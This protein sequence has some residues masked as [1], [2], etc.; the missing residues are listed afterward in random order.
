MDLFGTAEHPLATTDQEH[1]EEA[2]R[3]GQAIC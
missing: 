1:N 3:N 2:E